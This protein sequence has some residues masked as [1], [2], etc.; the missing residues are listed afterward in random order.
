MLPPTTG[1][2]L[3][4]NSSGFG[5]CQGTAPLT[6]PIG[7][8][9]VSPV[10]AGT[11]CAGTPVSFTATPTNLGSPVSYAWSSSPAG[12]SGSGAVFT[13]NAPNPIS[14][15]TYVI[16]VTATNGPYSATASAQ[17]TIRLRPVLSITPSTTAICTGQS[18]VLTATPGLTYLWSNTQIIQAISVSLTGTYTVTATNTNGCSNTAT[19]T[20]TGSTPVNLLAGNI[21]CTSPTATLT[22]TAGFTSYTFSSG[23]TQQGG[24]A[25]NTATVS[26]SGVYSVTAADGSGCR[27]TTTVTVT[28]SSTPTP[29]NLIASGT[30]SCPNPTVT[31]TATTGF[32]SYTFS[33]GATQQGGA[34]GNTATVSTSGVY[35]VTAADGNGC[36]STTTV[37]VTGGSTPTPVNLIASGTISCTNATVTL[38]ATA[39]FTS[40][41]FSSGATQ[42]GGAGGSTATVSTTGVFS[43]TATNANSCTSTNMVTVTGGG[44]PTPVILTHSGT[45]SCANPP[46][47]LTATPGFVSYVFSSGA[48]QQGGAGGNTA[49]VT[50]PG[51]YTV[52]AINSVGCSSTATAT[53][54]GN[55]TPPNA[56]FIVSGPITPTNSSVTIVVSGGVSYE[57]LRSVVNV[58]GYQIRQT[59]T[60]TTGQFVVTGVGPYL[61]T[62]IGPNGCKT[63]VVVNVPIGN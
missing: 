41:V 30:I 2:V 52:T 26:T 9:I 1:W 27:S 48:S 40:Y 45:V 4:D 62:V 57:L 7:S 6:T 24:A 46:A 12:F 55:I 19:A 50:T 22:A 10:S 14:T 34:A 42:Q 54:S 20:V 21:S 58:N 59:E 35:S 37:T 61:I 60:N 16:T 43:V 23:A 36:R 11:V 5:N 63:V 29:V 47:L 8:V 15:T 17:V 28:G 18:V 33:A 39:G 44:G 25:G 13:Q 51:V 32:V 38:T 31:L 3:V 56:S 53:V 49:T